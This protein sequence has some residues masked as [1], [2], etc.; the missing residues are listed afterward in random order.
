MSMATNP[1]LCEFVQLLFSRSGGTLPTWSL[2]FIMNR[3]A[4]IETRK[5]RQACGEQQIYR[6]MSR[7]LKT[8][9][10]LQR[11]HVVRLQPLL[12]TRYQ[13]MLGQAIS[14]GSQPDLWIPIALRISVSGERICHLVFVTT[15]T[16]EATL[17]DSEGP[18]HK[19]CDSVSSCL[20]Y[21]NAAFVAN[22]KAWVSLKRPI[23]QSV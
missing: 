13:A 19:T 11:A 12:H 16:V 7:L 3:I 1:E 9:L 6:F 18:V 17:T 2:S 20:A 8:R 14:S 10:R 4:T 5:R 21:L 23:S 15:Y 22:F